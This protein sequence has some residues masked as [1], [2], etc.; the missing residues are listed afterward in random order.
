M[1]QKWTSACEQ[2]N[3]LRCKKITRF[4]NENDEDVVDAIAKVQ[5][6][7]D[8]AVQVAGLRFRSVFKPRLKIDPFGSLL[9]LPTSE[10]TNSLLLKHT[11]T[12]S[13]QLSVTSIITAANGPLLY[14]Q[15]F[16]VGPHT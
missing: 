14:I 15:P 7:V 2:D 13:H 3:R 16:C 5:G 12:K 6:R 10:S 1:Q 8:P 4:Y 9:T 11:S